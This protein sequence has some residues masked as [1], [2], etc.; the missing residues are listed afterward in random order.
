[1]ND[2]DRAECNEVGHKRRFLSRDDDTRAVVT[3]QTSCG[4]ER[5]VQSLCAWS[6]Q[7][8]PVCLVK[9]DHLSSG[10]G[11]KVALQADAKQNVGSIRID[12]WVAEI[13]DGDLAVSKLRLWTGVVQVQVRLEQ[14]QAHLQHVDLNR[15][16]LAAAQPR[17]ETEGVERTALGGRLSK[18]LRYRSDVQLRIPRLV[19]VHE[20]QHDVDVEVVRFQL[21]L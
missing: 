4:H 6:G 16:E 18:N 19:N 21:E 7:H 11:L 13:H 2:R 17:L 8:V 12:K 20:G 10:L 15:V 1:M 14:C 9:N 3:L 5:L